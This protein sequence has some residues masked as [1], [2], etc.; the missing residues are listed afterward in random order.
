MLLRGEVC[1]GTKLWVPRL[2]LGRPRKR[3]AKVR[4]DKA[5][6]SRKNRAYRRRRGIHCTIPEKADQIRNP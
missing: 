2:G 3:P 6:G 5:Y 1:Q 4:A